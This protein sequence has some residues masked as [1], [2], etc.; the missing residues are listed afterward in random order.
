MAIQSMGAEPWAPRGGNLRL[1]SA[2]LYSCTVPGSAGSVPGPCPSFSRVLLKLVIGLGG[3]HHGSPATPVADRPNARGREGGWPLDGGAGAGVGTL[4]DHVQSGTVA[5]C[6]F[7]SDILL[8]QRARTTWCFRELLAP[9]TTWTASVDS[10]AAAAGRSWSRA[11]RAHPQV[12]EDGCGWVSTRGS[13]WGGGVWAIPG[14][15]GEAMHAGLRHRKRV[16]DHPSSVDRVPVSR[17]LE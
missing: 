5:R 6:N 8:V 1:D 10:A 16:C 2:S 3:H 4:P 13:R 11:R 17:S 7:R 15:E 14:K 12:E 9:L